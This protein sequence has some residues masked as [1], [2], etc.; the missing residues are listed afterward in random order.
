MERLTPIEDWDGD[1]R[2]M[3]EICLRKEVGFLA[4]AMVPFPVVD[5][6]GLVAIMWLSMN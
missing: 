5:D 2:L 1:L 4:P 6:V 3:Q